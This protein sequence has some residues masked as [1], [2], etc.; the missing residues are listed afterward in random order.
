MPDDETINANVKYWV[1][2]SGS[3]KALTQDSKQ[4][5]VKAAA[6][7]NYKRGSI[8]LQTKFE[9]GEQY[10]RL[11]QR[12]DRVQESLLLERRIIK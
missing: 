5:Q 6:R 2:F 11:Y 9:C 7:P 12:V 8:L 1:N 3:F 10:L 4:V